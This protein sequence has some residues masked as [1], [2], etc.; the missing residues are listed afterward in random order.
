MDQRF[1]ELRTHFQLTAKTFRSEFSNLYDWAVATTSALD[2]RL[3]HV[4]K[5]H[6]SR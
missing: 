2:T 5:D 4:E 1:D 6:G 3:G